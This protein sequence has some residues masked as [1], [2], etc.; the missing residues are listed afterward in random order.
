MTVNALQLSRDF[1]NLIREGY[2]QDSFYGDEGEWTKDSRIEAIAW[3]FWRL[4]R[5]CVPRNFELRLRL[6][7]ELHDISSVGHKG[8]ASTL[9]KTLYI[10]VEMNSQRRERFL[11]AV[12][13]VSR[14]K[15]SITDGCEYL[16]VACST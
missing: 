2:S 3:Y 11:W 9:A 4:D 12:R 7:T 14:N 6:I 1:D 13:R 5:L 15:N 16:P 10:L 8:V